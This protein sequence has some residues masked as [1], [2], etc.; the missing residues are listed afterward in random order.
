[1]QAYLGYYENM[2][3]SVKKVIPKKRRRP[4]TGNHPVTALRMP[5]ELTATVEGWANQ[6]PDKP[7]RSQAF[8]R[9]VEL[10]IAASAMTVSPRPQARAKAAEMAGKELDRLIDK[11]APTEE[12]ATRKRRLLKGPREFRDI[13]KDRPGRGGN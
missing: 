10:G 2:K 13:R 12:Q 9:L 3:R 7:T 5:K 4:A 1:L 11:S 8:R 6:Q